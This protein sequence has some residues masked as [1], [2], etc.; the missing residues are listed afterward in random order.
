MVDM[1]WKMVC[2]V[3]VMTIAFHVQAVHAQSSKGKTSTSKTTK[4][5]DKKESKK[6]DSA[7]K[8]SSDKDDVPKLK[9]AN[10]F[11]QPIDL[12]VSKLHDVT[13]SLDVRVA[14]F[15]T[16]GAD[17]RSITGST[18]NAVT[19]LPEG[20]S[21]NGARLR[22]DAYLNGRAFTS[23]FVAQLN[24]S[25]YSLKR[26]SYFGEVESFGVSGPGVMFGWKW[27]WTDPGE[28]GLNVGLMLGAY[29]LSGENATQTV[30][31]TL[32]DGRIELGFAF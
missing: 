13:F 20:T 11:I 4:D 12:V 26:E 1:R 6:S 2:A 25:F 22:A 14:R 19:A 8:R 16:V 24:Y 27:F 3:L 28:S 7:P 23:S 5:E 21:I 31:S 17:Y 15:V 29:N 9:V 32:L 30:N 10:V 18:S